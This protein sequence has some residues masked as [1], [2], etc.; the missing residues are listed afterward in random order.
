[1][2]IFLNKVHSVIKS[3]FGLKSVS[4]AILFGIAFFMTPSLHAQGTT[5]VLGGKVFDPG[6][7]VIQGAS[8]VVT[9]DESGVQWKAKTNEAG[10]WRVD[11]LVAG[12]YHF[13]VTAT[14]FAVTKHSSIDVQIADQKFVDV[15]LKVGDTSEAVTVTSETP[16]IDTTAAVSGTVLNSEELDELPGQ[17]NSPLDFVRLTPGVFL[18][19][20]S[21]GAALLWSNSSLST[22]TTNG[23]GS[24]TNAMNYMIDGATDTINSSGDVAFIPPSDAIREM[25]VMTNA[26][27]TSIERTAAGTV[28][29]TI[30]SGGKNF[31]GSLYFRDIN[32][33]F[34]ANYYQNHLADV[35]TPTVHLNEWGGT[36]GGPVWLPKLYDGKKRNTFFFFSYDGIH[37]TSPGATGYL[38]LP[39]QAE[40]NG[41]FSQSYTTNTTNGVTST[42]PVQIYDPNTATSS[43][44]RQPFANAIIPS[45]RTSAIATAIMNQ[46]PLPNKPSDGVSTD[47]NNYL[48]N[49]PKI[50]TFS[51]YIGRLDQA[52]N[53]NHHSYFEY[54]HN[55]F[56]E[57]AGDPFGPNN[58]MAAAYLTRTNDGATLSH[59]WV[60]SPN[61]LVNLLGNLTSFKTTSDSPANHL[62]VTDYGFSSQFAASQLNGGLPTIG[63]LFT[64][65][66]NTSGP[67]YENDYQYE[68]RASIQQIHNNHALR[69]GAGYMVQQEAT[70]SNQYGSGSYTFSSAWTTANPNATAGPG[71]G[72]TFASFLLGLPTSGYVTQNASAY[73]SQPY[74]GVFMQDDWRVK[75]RLTIS[76]GVRWDYQFPMTERHDK[77]WSRFDPNYNLTPVTDYSQPLYASTISGSSSNLGVQLLQQNRAD[78]SSFIA[79]GAILYAGQNGT[80]RSLTDPQ[81]KYIQP[82]VGVA[83]L[84]HPTTVLRGG[85]GR[86]VQGNYVANHASQLGYSA[87][88]TFDATSNNYVTPESTLDNPYPSGLV[89]VTGNALGVYTSPG[90]V[91]SFYSPDIKR[92]YTDDY[93]LHLQQQVKDYLFEIGGVYEFTNGLVVGYHKNNP[94][95]AQW[96]AAYGPQFDANG[97]PVD[98]LPGDTQ[99]QNPFKGSPYITNSLE[100]NS[101]VGAY[102]LLRPNPLLGDLVENFY[103]G[104]SSHYALQTKVQRH[105]RNGFAITTTFSWGKQMDRTGFVTNSVV[106]QNLLRQ[107]SSSDRRFQFVAAPSYVLPF[108]RGKFIGGN[109]NRV[110]DA[111]I[112]GWEVSANYTFYSGTP[113]SLP[114]D[115]AFYKGGD[116]GARGKKTQSQWFDT[117]QFVAFPTVSTAAADIHNPSLYPGW[118]GISN[119]PGYNWQPASSS[120]KTKNGVYHDFSTWSQNNPTYFGDVRNPY[121]NTWNLGLRKSFRIE[122]GVAVQLKLD[123]FN[124]LNH[125]QFGNIST[126]PTSKY[127][128]YVNGSNTLSQV[129]DPRNLQLGARIT[130]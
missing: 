88:T 47:S 40:R 130:F 55:Y 8:I 17:S 26:Y 105:L 4:V 9:S 57:L 12:H 74:L 89:P 77:Y 87:T 46:I 2:G 25:R 52:W 11:A 33:A 94:T 62:N 59:A 16:L 108:G 64:T 101:T 123:A 121:T 69:Y 45:G 63:G 15:T 75:P 30:K 82:R 70:G 23:A 51:S 92:Q 109:S 106:S 49:Q 111:F 56:S 35:P 102:Q 14:G 100:T 54:R 73:Y 32:N 53:N 117:S 34:N 98:T 20:A 97:R 95:V 116:P 66:G 127:F 84:L 96:Q 7:N 37:N 124:A 38:S 72:S 36:V 19:P 41:D 60:L 5:S 99:V 126:S 118:T 114:T 120:D 28:N 13:S 29:M 129:N 67:S 119:L 24:G 18:G 80:S 71:V 113:I 83:F 43:G 76:M 107:I 27:D 85:F 42:Y 86:F 50:D 79:R 104:K 93:S 68:V 103:N 122:G 90:S 39:T 112:G 78:V 31:H 1:M 115:S 61:L 22:I 21:G 91:T 3:N 58:L 125:P 48:I 128:G 6:G 81:Y 10:N 65:L 44:D 110:V